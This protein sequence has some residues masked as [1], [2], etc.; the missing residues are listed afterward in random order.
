LPI[1][2]RCSMTRLQVM[3]HAG[4]VVRYD[5]RLHSLIGFIDEVREMQ[6]EEHGTALLIAN[7]ALALLCTFGLA[8][9]VAKGTRRLLARPSSPER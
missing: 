5:W 1:Y 8:S 9:V 7:L 6:P 3:G 4:D 2:V